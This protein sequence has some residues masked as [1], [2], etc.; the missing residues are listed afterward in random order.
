MWYRYDDGYIY[1]VDPYSRTI[2]NVYPMSYG[3]EVGYPAPAY[4]LRRVW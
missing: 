1:G 2:R 4:S 3:Y